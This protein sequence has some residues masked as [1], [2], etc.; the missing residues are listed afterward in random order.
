MATKQESEGSGVCIL[1]QK[2]CSSQTI[3]PLKLHNL[4]I[5]CAIGH[6]GRPPLPPYTPTSPHIPT[7]ATNVPTAGTPGGDPPKANTRRAD[8]P[9]VGQGVSPVG[10]PA[11]GASTFGGSFVCGS[12]LR[13]HTMRRD[14]FFC[15]PIGLA[16]I[17]GH[18]FSHF[19][20][21]SNFTLF[22]FA[23]N[24]SSEVFCACFY[25]FHVPRRPNKSWATP[26]YNGKNTMTLLGVPL[27][28]RY[29]Q[30]PQNVF[31]TRGSSLERL[32]FAHI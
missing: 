17:D 31:P 20:F 16:P 8:S 21:C 24:L 14:L 3:G 5:C 1:V 26:G 10:V 13:A 4:E 11:F 9:R 15:I 23:D 7:P 18:L 29:G 6:R 30:M 12:A 19:L 32:W 25:Q 2:R 27:S 22:L 28:S